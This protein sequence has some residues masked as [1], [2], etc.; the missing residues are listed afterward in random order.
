VEHLSRFDARA[1]EQVLI[2]HDGLVNLYNRINSIA[3]NNPVYP[4]SIQRGTEILREIGFL[5]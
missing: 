1:V 4:E 3:A 5:E 2:E